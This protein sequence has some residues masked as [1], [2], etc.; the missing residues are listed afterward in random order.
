MKV[1]PS[2][3]SGL[4]QSQK[5]KVRKRVQ[6]SP[7]LFPPSCFATL[8]PS[9]SSLGQ[10]REMLRATKVWPEWHKRNPSMCFLGITC[11]FFLLKVLLWTFLKTLPPSPLIIASLTEAMSPL[12]LHSFLATLASNVHPSVAGHL[13]SP[14]FLLENIQHSTRL[15]LLSC[16]HLVH[17]KHPCILALLLLE[18]QWAPSAALSLFSLSLSSSHSHSCSLTLSATLKLIYSHGVSYQF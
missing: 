2:P 13:A 15:A 16:P 9:L 6:E 1:F 12:Q 4:P 5:P 11:W 18:I 3:S 7:F 14:G 10:V 17:K 8:L